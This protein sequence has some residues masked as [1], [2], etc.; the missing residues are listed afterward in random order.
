[1]A[2]LDPLQVGAR[3]DEHHLP[4]TNG[5]MAVCRRCGSR[6]DGPSGHRHTPGE[7]QLVRSDKWLDAEAHLSRINDERL[8]RSAL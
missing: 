2:S 5:R 6:T 4:E 1:M 8:R 7:G 3:L